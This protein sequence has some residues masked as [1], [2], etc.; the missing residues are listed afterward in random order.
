VT[1]STRSEALP[2][3]PTVGDFVPG[4][5]ASVWFGAGAPRNTLAE[6]VDKLNK[7][8]NAGLADPRVKA[9]LAELGSVPIPMTSAEFGT[10]STEPTGSASCS[11]QCGGKPRPFWLKRP[12]NEQ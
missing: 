12:L 9:R 8:I 10:Q 7:E 1:T 11:R 2:D 4:Y 6:I 3:V 5:E